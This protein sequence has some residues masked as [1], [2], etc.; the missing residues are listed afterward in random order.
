M[1][2]FRASFDR[3]KRA[4]RIVRLEE[5]WLTPV[6]YLPYIDALFG[7]I[8]LDPC[9]TEEANKQ[10]LRARNFYVKEDDGLNIEIPW[11]GKVYLFPPTYGCCS[12][13]NIRGTWK[14]GTRGGLQGHSPTIAWFKRLLKEWKLGNVTEGLMFSINHEVL[15]KMPELWDYPVCIPFDRAN[16]VHGGRFYKM[17]N[18][19]TWGF[20]VYLP[21]RSLEFDAS[22][23]FKEIFGHIGKVIC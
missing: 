11:T 2:K 5:D 21:P 16:L 10:F 17:Q 1:S 19:V 15:R 8:D 3:Y 12:W 7:D 6:D 22:Q 18:P 4:L 14:W 13:S 20:F 9:T 23:R